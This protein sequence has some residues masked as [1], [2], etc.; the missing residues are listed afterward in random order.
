MN[1]N[2][3][4]HPNFT[5]EPRL[6]SLIEENKQLSQQLEKLKNALSNYETQNQHLSLALQ[7]AETLNKLSLEIA[8]KHQLRLIVIIIGGCAS[9]FGFI[10]L[11][12]HLNQ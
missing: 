8:P 10:F 3:P 2:H 11:L 1:I 7:N 4:E 6:E 12:W 5:L 9:L